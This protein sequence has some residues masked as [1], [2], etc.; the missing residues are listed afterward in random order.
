MTARRR[1]PSDQLEPNGY[2]A[3]IARARAQVS[4]LPTERLVRM[5]AALE[6]ALAA[7]EPDAEALAELARALAGDV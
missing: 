7:S 1:D 2:E 3:L 4:S 6:R 5:R